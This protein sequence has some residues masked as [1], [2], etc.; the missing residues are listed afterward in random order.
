MV[1]SS[2]TRWPL[3]S[4][5][6]KDWNRDG[7]QDFVFKKS[8]ATQSTTRSFN[9]IRRE[10]KEIN[11]QD[12]SSLEEFLG[13]KI[14]IN[15]DGLEDTITAKTEG[16]IVLPKT[17]VT[18]KLN[19]GDNSETSNSA[20]FKLRTANLLPGTD[21]SSA[22]VD[23]NLDGKLDLNL[24][25][26]EISAASSSSMIE[27]FLDRGIKSKLYIY[28]WDDETGFG[29]RPDIRFPMVLRYDMF[30]IQDVEGGAFQLGHDFNGDGRTDLASKSGPDTNRPAPDETG[31]KKFRRK[32]VAR[33]T[34]TVQN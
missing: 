14:D 11:F 13:T 1:Y 26:F 33:F 10:N 16:D 31:W 28:L 12:D 24:I 32:R 25:H 34:N 15:G 22:L 23:V 8:I 17:V 29:K 27:S 20:P 2:I 21:I 9:T 19:P 3:N 30:G 7:L 5:E 18:V 4:F 6:I